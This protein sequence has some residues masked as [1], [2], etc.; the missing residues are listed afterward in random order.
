MARR[1]SILVALDGADEGLKR[2]LT[3]AERS[4][5][6]LAT[7]AKTAGDKAA[8]GL[9]EVKAG[10]SAFGEQIQRAKG[11]LLAFVTLSWAAGQ[12][13][14]IV[15]VA[16][17]W[18]SM[19]AR[20]KLATAGQREFAIA[21]EALFAIAQRIGVPLEETAKLYGKLQQSVRQLGGEQREAL[22]IT[23]SIA[24][25]LRISG[26]SATEAQSSLLQFGQ[27]LA[28]GVLR[29]EEFNSV[30]EN[31]PRLAQALAD[32]LNVPIGRLRKLA[33]EGRLTA[34]VV[35]QALLSQKGKL[36]TEYAQ[37]PQ[38]VG[39]A[40]V[41]L[42]NAFGQW[43]NQ[44]D[45]ATG[46]TGKLA[47]AMTTLGDHLGTVMAVLTKLAEVGLGV[48]IYRLL[49]ALI[50]GWQT[51]AAAGVAAANATAAAWATVNL[52]VSTAVASVGLLKAAFGVLSALLIGWEIG[53]WLQEKFAV[54][55]Q[56][57]ILMVQGLLTGVEL[58]RYG[59]EAFAALFTA[60]TIA[61]AT[62]RHQARLTEMRQIFGEMQADAVRGTAAAQQ[63]MTAAGDTAESIAQ[64]LNAVRQGTQEAVGRGIEA[65]N[66]AVG[67]LKSALGEVEQESSKVGQG[68]TDAMARLA[69]AYQGL[70]A[71]AEAN[72]QQQVDAVKARTQHEQ[73]A[74][75]T[76][77]A[78]QRVQIAQSTQLL[79]DAL[80]QQTSLRRQASA[81]TLQLIEAEAQARLT[82]AAR[83]G[84][85]E[86][87]RLANLRRVEAE[88]L[89][90][91]QQALTQALAEYRQ[92]IDALNA[93]AQR[94][95]AEVKRIED[96]KRL[97]QASTEERIRELQRTA[98][99][100]YEAYQDKL[101]QVTD[102]QAKARQA[103][104]AGEYDRAQAFAKQAQELAAQTAGAVVEGDRTIVTQKEAVAR[105]ISAIRDAEQLALQALEGEGAA[106]QQA[107]SAALAAR[108][109]IEKSLGATQ[110]QI[111]DIESQL[112]DGFTLAID[113]DTQ[114]VIAAV[115]ELDQLI[116][117]RER[118]LVIK[119][120]L[121]QAQQE[122]QRFAQLLKEGKDLPVGADVSKAKA[123]LDQLKLY[124][125]E[126]SNVE[127]R[128]ATDK[129]QSALTL[130]ESQIR[131][132]DRIQTES[133]HTVTS[134]AAAARQ[135]VIALDGVTTRSEHLITVR[136]VEVNAAGGLAGSGMA[137][138][139]R[140]GAVGGFARLAGG[141][142]P[143][144]G[145]GDTVPRT[146]DAGAFVLRK[147]AV[148]KYGRRALAKLA[149]GVARFATGGV[150]DKAKVQQWAD[151]RWGTNPNASRTDTP[152]TAPMMD[153]K[154]GW[155]SGDS[156]Q[157]NSP[158]I[159]VDTRPVPEAL[160]NAAN[161]L[162][163]AREMLTW[164]SNSPLLGSLLPAITQGIAA[165]EGN[166][167]DA[168]AI[169]RLLQAAETIGANPYVFAMWEKT[170]GAG[171][172]ENP[173]WFI[174][175]LQKNR[176]GD[177]AGG[178]QGSVASSA[179]SS[180]FAQRSF[181]GVDPAKLNGPN[182][183]V[184]RQMAQGGS[185]GTDT[186][187]ALLTPG[188]YV[189]N[190]QAVG[191]Y[192]AG[193]FAALNAMALPARTVAERVRGYASGGL[194]GAAARGGDLGAALLDQLALTM[195]RPTLAYAAS[196]TTPSRT[197]RVELV[198]GREKVAATVDGR[199]E[200][201]LLELLREARA[202]SQ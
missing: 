198:A 17:A 18:N 40:F 137:G 113:A 95:L 178:A 105:A 156:F 193:F 31:S 145:D 11:Q 87:E 201:R 184:R 96:E 199:D 16:D 144:T 111:K 45:T 157:S 99:G 21:Q 196:T 60:D 168:A 35:V 101:S 42:Q 149:N 131:A 34:D 82:A 127:L 195:R 1:I 90:A 93:N 75:E 46:A 10:A 123:A 164:R 15:Q 176:A 12:V 167:R 23:E 41:R 50:T 85:T 171:R 37:L 172:V 84:K 36:A 47:A 161:V 43:L 187:P 83:Q 165:V 109:D 160:I 133:R 25:A 119:A 148:R 106:H 140:G 130:V 5:G 108:A 63:A 68:L 49:P 177:L 14:E 48:L 86:E 114:R 78:A 77:T 76:S 134:N 103:L 146:L 94:H 115:T 200:A 102:L 116:T 132:L 66:A 192:G 124:A 191:R 197:I 44:V 32:G 39:Q 92:H 27:A 141:S 73:A 202:R 88:I 173:I 57:G 185:T 158:P 52:S 190:K 19:A 182:P 28:A 30:V 26:A 72:L 120:D 121:E 129:A 138:F 65:V 163:Y 117:E 33:E 183:L 74:L 64:R 122:L 56:A 110:Q 81:T 71:Q 58:L 4:L 126:K 13:R 69:S 166:P 174:D 181:S 6:E 139:A 98:M 22:T 67:K 180:E 100:S 152:T 155:C 150:V 3:S 97:L 80:T 20:L 9:A 154:V 38:T 135:E 70:G 51:A 104:N 107:A 159:A 170:A 153:P 62:Q 128:V 125:D 147:A 194:V 59:W 151:A 61:A 118:L 112:K 136:R 91:K 188:E 89:A 186:V 142:V 179:P 189:V 162:A 54:V 55:R 7:S 169:K 24:Q 2:A 53:T 8:A 79:V 143:G 175:W 29:G